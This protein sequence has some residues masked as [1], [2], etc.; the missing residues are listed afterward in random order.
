VRVLLTTHVFLPD[1]ASGTETLTF[2]TAKELQRLGHE[3]EI[4]TGFP[5]RPGLA[6]DE[7]FDVYEYEGIP[8]RRFLHDNAPMGGQSNVVEAEYNN[9][10]Y[11]HWFRGYLQQFRPDVVHFFHLQL[12]SASTIDV[13]QELGVP[14]VMTPTDFWLICPNVQLRLPDNS[15]CRGPDR[16]SVNCM[17]HAVSIK[18]SPRVAKVF[19]LLPNRAVAT[20]IWGINQGAFSGSWFSPMVRA[21]DQRAA[22]LRERMNRLDRAVVPTRLMEEMLVANGLNP[23]KVVYSRFG[24]RSLPREPHCP[25]V[26]G[27]LRIGFIGGLGEHKGAH[28]L[29]AAVRRLS[30]VDDLELRI[31]GRTDLNPAY[32]AKLQGLAEAD[33][34][35]HFCETFPNEI[36]GKIFAGLDVLVVPSIWYENSPLVIYSAQAAGCPVIA[37]N[38]GGMAEVVE[39]EK[40]GLL[41][42]AG[43]VAGLSSAI[44]R[45]VGDRQLLQ[46]LAANAIKPKSIS[47]Y[48]SELQIIYEQVLIERS[49]EK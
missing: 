22:F 25:D 5:A 36:I 20:M 1:Y 45:L 15:L 7:R 33:P 27:K 35:I 11:A 29:I 10:F 23:D 21:L 26:A 46:Q 17:R 12:L 8:V 40:N 2:N 24:I 47:D 34:R 4:C 9:T 3:V 42:E 37:S 30:T 28:L 39:H 32:F 49:G 13:C 38:L 44:E 48:V 6:D 14:M 41:F 31:Y 19:N 43:D 16:D 18:Q